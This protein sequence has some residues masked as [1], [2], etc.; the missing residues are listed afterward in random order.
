[1]LDALKDKGWFSTFHQVKFMYMRYFLAASCWPFLDMAATCLMLGIK[2][3]EACSPQGVWVS[4]FGHCSD[5]TRSLRS[6]YTPAAGDYF[7]AGD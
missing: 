7:S 2:E 1:M 3:W 5:R 4:S 6:C